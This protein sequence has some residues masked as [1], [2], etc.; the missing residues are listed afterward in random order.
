[1]KPTW[2]LAHA[3]HFKDLDIKTKEEIQSFFCD[4]GSSRQA[5]ITAVQPHGFSYSLEDQTLGYWPTKRVTVPVIIKGNSCKS[6]L[7]QLC[8]YLRSQK[9]LLACLNGVSSSLKTNCPLSRTSFHLKKISFTYMDS[10]VWDPI[11]ETGSINVASLE[12]VCVNN[13]CSHMQGFA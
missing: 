8:Y 3:I 5:Q 9:H 1:M 4:W 6:I 10:K 7:A 2:W 11:W 12:T 13:V